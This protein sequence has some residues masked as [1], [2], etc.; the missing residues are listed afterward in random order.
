MG[1]FPPYIH[2][3]VKGDLATRYSVSL[4]KY[5]RKEIVKT[6]IELL[7]AVAEKNPRTIPDWMRL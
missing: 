2:G 4:T 6:F 3:T 7:R 5:F 1:E